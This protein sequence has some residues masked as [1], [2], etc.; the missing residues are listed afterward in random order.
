MQRYPWEQG[1]CA[2]ALYEAGLDELSDIIDDPGSFVDG[3]SSMM[4]A[5]VIYRGNVGGC[6]DFVTQGTSAEAQAAYIMASAWNLLSDS[7]SQVPHL[8]TSI[9][10]TLSSSCSHSC[11]LMYSILSV[12]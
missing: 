4:T 10:L 12:H 9:Y 7:A 6:P 8:R 5:A 2:Q 11:S 3:T 1:V